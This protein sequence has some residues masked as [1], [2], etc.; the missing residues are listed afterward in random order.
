MIWD[1]FFLKTMNS[2]R[3]IE[4]I[5]WSGVVGLVCRDENGSETVNGHENSVLRSSAVSSS[6]SGHYSSIRGRSSLGG[7]SKGMKKMVV[8]DQMHDVIVTSLDD[9]ANH[10]NHTDIVEAWH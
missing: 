6:R 3:A 5:E 4:L 7:G 1:F 8:L 9:Y 2:C 10:Y